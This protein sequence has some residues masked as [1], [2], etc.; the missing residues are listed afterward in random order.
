MPPPDKYHSIHTMAEADKISV[1]KDT[2]LNPNLIQDG[3]D[4]LAHGYH[5]WTQVGAKAKTN[6]NISFSEQQKIASNFY[7]AVIA[8][9]YGHIFKDSQDARP[10]SKELWMKQAYEDALN[11]KIEDAYT[12]N[13]TRSIKNGWNSAMAQVATAADKVTTMLGNTYSSAVAQYRKESAWRH[14][15]DFARQQTLKGEKPEEVLQTTKGFENYTPAD[16]QNDAYWIHRMQDVDHQLDLDKKYD[17]NIIQR[18]ARWQ[19]EHKEFW[20]DVIPTHGGTLNKATSFVAE[21][22]GQAPIFAAISL[23]MEPLAAAGKVTNLTEAL[24]KTPVGS[25]MLGY[26]TSGATGLAYGAAVRTQDDPNEM[27]R[28]AVGFAVF[29]G[30]FDVAGMGAKKL[31]DIVP[32]G[33]KSMAELQR[34]QDLYMLAQEGKRLATP[35]E[36]YSDHKTEVAN[37][38]YATGI[39]GQR[40][41]FVDALHH[42][43]E[44]ETVH[45]DKIKETEKLLLERDPARYAPVLSSARFI[46]SLLGEKKL[47]D[48]K[49]GSE[50]EQFLS[51]RIARLIVDASGEMNARVHGMADTVAEKAAQDITKPSAKHA[52]EYYVNQ[53]KEE[54][55]GTPAG[56]VTEEQILKAAQKRFA[57]DSQKAAALA[58]KEVNANPVEKAT[59][60]GKREKA[61]KPIPAVKIRSEYTVNKYGEPAARYQVVPEFKV[62][63]KQYAKEAKAQGKTLTQ[64]FTDMDDSDFAKDLSTHFYPKALQDAG[65]FFEKQNTRE[66]V[67][68]PNFLA[69]MYNYLNM[70]PKE[71][72]QELE[73]RFIDTLKV[74]KYMK[75]KEPTEPQL[76]YYAKAMYNHVDNFLGSGRF[77]AE[78]NIFRSS[79]PNMFKTSKWQRQLLVEKTLQEQNNLKEMFSDNP[80]AKRIALATHAAFAKLRMNEFERASIKRDSQRLIRSYDEII[81]DL[82]T[83][84]GSYDRWVF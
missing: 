34:R 42:I 27:W 13:W 66:G 71:F 3:Y 28:D 45:P 73:Q 52:L 37:N 31:I 67:Q 55:A 4:Q 10:L 5:L 39:A 9:A 60:V 11:Y 35:V 38:I 68:N 62:Q 14:L 48:I 50:E 70:M 57:E 77:P 29:H 32:K 24:T 43:E 51:S 63:L 78:H 30:V 79:N 19:S 59:N 12:N 26:L 22:V 46:R 54:A 23:G 18:G 74:Q 81:A 7:D 56:M 76:E 16:R 44:M 58:E 33:S 2:K 20:A 21:Q 15:S 65:V 25:K 61:S 17:E 41:I 69:F 83:Q 8:P 1:L 47:S 82:Q 80:K 6:P 64:F 40:A 49:P 75:G 36:Q 72:G 53:V 84:T